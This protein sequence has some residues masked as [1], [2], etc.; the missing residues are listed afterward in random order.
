[1]IG[2]NALASIRVSSVVSSRP[3]SGLYQLNGCTASLTAR[4]WPRRP[5]TDGQA[6]IP[7]T[8]RLCAAGIISMNRR[9][10]GVCVQV[11]P[12]DQRVAAV[13]AAARAVI[14][15]EPGPAESL[16]KADCV[17]AIGISDCVCV[18]ALVQVGILVGI[19]RGLD[20]NR[21]DLAVRFPLETRVAVVVRA[22]FRACRS[23][24][25]GSS[26][27][28]SGSSLPGQRKVLPTWRFFVLPSKL[29][30]RAL[31]VASINRI[32]YRRTNCSLSSSRPFGAR[33]SMIGGLLLCD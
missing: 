9:G 7:L 20:G 11:Q 1:M 8:R 19:L 4:E 21:R 25:S 3:R 28:G 26:C 14:V 30:V 24:W 29:V 27:R 2:I 5:P 32:P 16:L 22:A 13:A 15:A 17:D 18:I 12:D 10:A 33:C 23:W 6:D 31:H